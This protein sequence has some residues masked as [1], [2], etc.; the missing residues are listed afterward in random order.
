MPFNKIITLYTVC[1]PS[2]LKDKT[3]FVL[4]FFVCLS[5]PVGY[6]KVA[7]VGECFLIGSVPCDCDFGAATN[8]TP[9]SDALPFITGHITQRDEYLREN[10]R[11]KIY[12]NPLY[13]MFMTFFCIILNQQNDGLNKHFEL[14]IIDIIGI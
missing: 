11:K 12:I 5:A 9:Q 4:I 8:F 2:K 6:T 14:T 1:I 3:F 13:Y 7:I 10:W